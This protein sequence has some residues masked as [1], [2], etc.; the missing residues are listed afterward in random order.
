MRYKWFEIS[1][2]IDGHWENHEDDNIF[3]LA[4][5]LIKAKGEEKRVGSITINFPR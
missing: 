2:K 4:Y 1:V 3:K 5:R